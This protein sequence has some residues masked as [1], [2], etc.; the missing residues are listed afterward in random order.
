MLMFPHQASAT[1]WTFGLLDIWT[2]GHLDIWTFGLLDI[3]T[4]GLLDIWTFGHLDILRYW[5]TMY[6]V[7]NTLNYTLPLYCTM[8]NATCTQY[9]QLQCTKQF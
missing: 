3:W 2:F 1:V 5:T 8:N 7:L 6:I 4:F 9:T